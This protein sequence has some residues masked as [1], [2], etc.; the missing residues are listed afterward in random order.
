MQVSGF[1]KSNK[2]Y[3][4]DKINRGLF[5]YASKEVKKNKS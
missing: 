4:R 5:K 3:G 2:K 1:R